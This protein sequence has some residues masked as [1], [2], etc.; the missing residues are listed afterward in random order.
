[1]KCQHWCGD[2]H[3]HLPLGMKRS[4]HY[5]GGFLRYSVVILY[6]RMFNCPKPVEHWIHLLLASTSMDDHSA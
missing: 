4:V 3:G 6:L 5:I 1:M 2:A